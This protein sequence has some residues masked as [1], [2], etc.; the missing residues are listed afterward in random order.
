[1]LSKIIDTIVGIIPFDKDIENL[2][3][4][5]LTDDCEG[6]RKIIDPDYDKNLLYC[7]CAYKNNYNILNLLLKYGVNKKLQ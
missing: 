3:I 7:F 2:F 5:Q 1:M 4:G 6:K